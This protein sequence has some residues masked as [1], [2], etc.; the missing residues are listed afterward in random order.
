MATYILPSEEGVITKITFE[1][2]NP[3]QKREQMRGWGKGKPC[4]EK[5]CLR[6]ISLCGGRWSNADSAD[7][8]DTGV[9]SHQK[10]TTDIP[11]AMGSFDHETASDCVNRH[12]VYTCSHCCICETCPSHISQMASPPCPKE[13]ISHFKRSR[14]KVGSY[15]QVSHIQE[16]PPPSRINKNVW[17]P[18]GKHAQRGRGIQNRGLE[19]HFMHF[20]YSN[21]PPWIPHVDVGGQSGRRSLSQRVRRDWYKD[22][23]A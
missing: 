12:S 6:L 4:K 1:V 19:M 5:Q 14:H 23:P 17:L 13:A 16:H 21:G 10:L 8:K 3:V 18:N 9:I 7:G 20:R 2:Q 15:H 11:G 22:E